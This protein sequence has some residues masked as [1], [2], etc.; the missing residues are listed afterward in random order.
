MVSRN[1][2]KELGLDSGPKNLPTS[3]T[4]AALVAIG[5]LVTAFVVVL[6]SS[7]RPHAVAAAPVTQA[8]A[9]GQ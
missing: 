2:T 3:V 8:V 1:Y 6:V 9:A 4:I 7:A 5:A